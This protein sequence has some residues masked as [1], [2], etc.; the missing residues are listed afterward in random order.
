MSSSGLV[1]INV[2]TQTA[3]IEKGLR[4]C[5]AKHAAIPFAGLAYLALSIASKP[6]I[7]GPTKNKSTTEDSNE[8]RGKCVG[9][10]VIGIVCPFIL[11]GW[12][13]WS[14]VLDNRYI[15]L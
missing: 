7:F 2:C 15:G 3:L 12:C 4:L 9:I 14:K 5:P 6:S 10:F 8:Y 13:A 1:T 11:A